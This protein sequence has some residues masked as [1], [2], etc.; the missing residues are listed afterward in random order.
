MKTHPILRYTIGDSSLG[1]LLVAAGE[2]GVCAILIDDDRAA[3]VADLQ[4]RFRHAELRECPAADNPF[5]EQVLRSVDDPSQ[6]LTAP[7]ELHGTPFQRRVWDALL[8]IPTGTTTN[9][10][11]IARRIGAP[12]SSRAVGAAIAANPLAVVVPCHRVLRSDGSLSGYRWG[13]DRKRVLLD[14]ESASGRQENSGIEPRPPISRGDA[15]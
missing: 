6:P 10:A 14:R 3:L 13:V 4:R 15:A 8:A 9:Y 2:R 11:D 5:F 12:T 1:L 7:L